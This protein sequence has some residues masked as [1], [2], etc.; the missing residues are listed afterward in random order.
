MTY[1]VDH[2]CLPAR[3]LLLETLNEEILSHRSPINLPEL[4][5]FVDVRSD[6]KHNEQDVAGESQPSN[7]SSLAVTG[8]DWTVN[9]TDGFDLSHD[10]DLNQDPGNFDFNQGLNNP[11]LNQ[12]LSGTDFSPDSTSFD[13]NRDLNNPNL[14]Q[15]LSGT[16]FNQ[17]S[18]NFDFSQDV[19]N[20]DLNEDFSNL[21]D[22]TDFDFDQNE[23]H[24]TT[25]AL[26][27][28]LEGS[29]NVESSDNF[30]LSTAAC[31]DPALLQKK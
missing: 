4:L 21:D 26:V 14:N 10:F 30:V 7:D 11:N 25:T 17:D 16:D 20:G 18:I 23:S 28:N 27:A 3:P 12:N 13:F 31:I 9:A 19:D 22:F 5:S 6:L 29:A 15:N 2:G 8:S 24:P 1:I